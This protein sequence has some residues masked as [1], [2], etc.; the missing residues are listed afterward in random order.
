MRYGG[1]IGKGVGIMGK[2]PWEN[3]SQLEIPACNIILSQTPL[4]M[5]VGISICRCDIF[6][7][8]GVRL[9]VSWS[10]MSNTAICPL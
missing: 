4:F 3:K 9:K 7:T 2:A 10:L 8:H 1:F 6:L 5:D